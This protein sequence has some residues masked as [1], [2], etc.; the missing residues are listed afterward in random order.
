VTTAGVAAHARTRPEKVAIVE[1]TANGAER[2]ITYC[3]LDERITRAARALTRL[4]IGR[5][6]RVLVSLRNRPEMLEA[7]LGAARVRAEIVCAAWRSTT[8]ELAYLARDAGASLVI[9]EETARA[10][11]TALGLPA[12]HMGDEYETAVGAESSEPLDPVGVDYVNLHVYTSGTTGRPKAIQLPGFNP[13]HAIEHASEHQQR[14]GLEGPDEVVLA[15]CPMHHLAG[16]SYPHSALVLGQTVALVD[17]FDPELVLASI[18]RER[19]T[20]LNL[21]PYHFIRIAALPVDV[22]ERYDVSSVRALLHGSAPCPVDVKWRMMEIFGPDIIWETYGG[23]EGMASVISPEEWREHPGSVGCP[24]TELRILDDEGRELPRGEPGLIYLAPRAGVRF[25]YRGDAEQS[26]A[27]WR[28]DLFTLGDVGYLDDDGY[29]FLVDRQKD[30]IVTG[31]ANVYP[32]EV[33]V[34]LREHPAVAEAAVVGV[35]D[36]EWGERVHAVVV[37]TMDVEPDEVVAFCRERLVRGKCPSTLEFV[38]ELPRDPMGKV[39]RRA[40]RDRYWAGHARKI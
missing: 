4:G 12:V 33:E 24:T 28:G 26:R 27:I 14:F 1:S 17:G 15:V 25:E 13:V 11:T 18:E 35:P 10:A 38:D 8:D 21:V 40:L 39:R 9:A 20:Y 32:A 19:V 2:R 5:G 31:G 6:D 37:A 16:W 22:V 29:L 36:Q 34:V 30:V 3:E 7:A 23:S